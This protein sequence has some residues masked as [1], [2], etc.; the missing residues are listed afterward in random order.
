[1][2]WV[3][4]S[5]F[6]LSLPGCWLM[7][8]KGGPDNEETPEAGG[9]GD[10]DADADSDVDADSDA[11]ADSD[12][13]ADADSDMDTDTDTPTDPDAE[14][15]V[16]A[17]HAGGLGSDS[18]DAI[19]V[20]DDGACIVAGDAAHAAIF[21]EGDAQQIIFDQ[22]VGAH[23]SFI[24]RFEPDG[25]LAWVERI[26]GE[27]R[28]KEIL[29]LAD[30]GF[31]LVGETHWQI[32]FAPDEPAETSIN[33]QA[34]PFYIARYMSSG[35]F[36]W[37]NTVACEDITS[38][39]WLTVKGSVEVENYDIVV[40]GSMTGPVVFGEGT[41]HETTLDSE[42]GETFIARYIMGSYLDSAWWLIRSDMGE[43]VVDVAGTGTD[44]FAVVGHCSPWTTFGSGDSAVNL[45]FEGERTSYVAR[46]SSWG[47]PLWIRRFTCDG[48]S[49]GGAEVSMLD[50]GSVF[51]AFVDDG[52]EVVVDP[53]GPNETVF[54]PGEISEYLALYSADGELVWV[55]ELVR[56]I[57]DDTYGGHNAVELVTTGDGKALVTGFMSSDVLFAPDTADELLIEAGAEWESYLAKIGPDGDLLWARQGSSVGEGATLMRTAGLARSTSGGVYWV[58][59]YKEDAVF[60]HEAAIEA[61]LENYSSLGN[62][63]IYLAKYAP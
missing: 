54:G 49:C 31:Y 29:T 43:N 13:D 60:L 58:G 47:E 45:E 30:G 8:P 16:W 36:V 11:D 21:G 52:E 57:P 5:L 6:V 22:H 51:V 27:A 9:A 1:M 35:Q 34:H 26:E 17:V 38:C 61:Q 32:T 14:A 3:L 24:A 33:E 19:A 23:G 48:D 7:G 4:L 63:D 37:V 28:V 62:E 53:G 55:R 12:S 15:L 2:R 25:E 59:R 46:F 50:D 41:D 44:S 39:G 56:A 42:L 18:I 40:I 10:A 20:T